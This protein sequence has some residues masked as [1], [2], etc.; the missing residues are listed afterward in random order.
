MLALALVVTALPGISSANHNTCTAQGSSDPNNHVAGACPEFTPDWTIG[1]TYPFRDTRANVNLMMSQRAHESTA[2]TW[3]WFLPTEWRFNGA[4]RQGQRATGGPAS[5]CTDLFNPD[6]SMPNAEGV[7]DG[8]G[9]SGLVLGGAPRYWGAMRA[10]SDVDNRRPHNAQLGYWRTVGS[11]TTLC[12]LLQTYSTG[13][14]QGLQ[15]EGGDTIPANK[16]ILPI[17]LERGDFGNG[18]GWRVHVPTEDIA[19]QLPP[20]YDFT[21][22]GLDIEFDGL[23]SGLWHLENGIPTRTFFSKTPRSPIQT[24]IGTRAVACTNG[25]NTLALCADEN[26][27]AF[28]YSG[29]REY[30]VVIGLPPAYQPVPWANLTRAGDTVIAGVG[31][32]GAKPLR[33]YGFSQDTTTLAV[34]WDEVAPGSLPPGVTATGYVV[35]VHKFVKGNLPTTDEEIAAGRVAYL[36][37]FS[38]AGPTRALSADLMALEENAR[39]GRVDGKY[40]VTLVTV[41]DTPYGDGYRSDGLCDGPSLDPPVADDGRGVL[42]PADRPIWVAAGSGME[43]G[44]SFIQV[45]VRQDAWQRRYVAQVFGQPLFLLLLDI[46]NHRGEVTWWGNVVL[47]PTG[48]N[49][50]ALGG[51]YLYG[52]AQGGADMGPPTVFAQTS[53]L[54]YEPT[55]PASG[56]VSFGNLDLESEGFTWNFTAELEAPPGAARGQFTM[57]NARGGDLDWLK[58]TVPEGDPATYPAQILGDVTDQRP[59]GH[60]QT[61]TGNFVGNRF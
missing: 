51:A 31:T 40:D 22:T 17:T 36:R 3:E 20:D 29:L 44:S 16:I 5:S 56:I 14:Q 49:V 25:E 23:T 35:G 32:F 8:V 4:I 9:M 30:P 12:L 50:P 33:A 41:Y 1:V 27:I 37:D 21:L 34:T 15:G 24:R 45:M 26:E 60:P 47:T 58:L 61:V 55:G 10:D 42:C 54:M 28:P 2:L 57:Y 11:T 19:P 38:N 52:M 7:A 18:Y 43:R 6:G 13:G 46:P 48:P 53:D 39:L 59:S